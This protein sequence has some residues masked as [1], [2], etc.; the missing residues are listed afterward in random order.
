MPAQAGIHD[1]LANTQKLTKT[2]LIPPQ[3]PRHAGA[4]GHLCE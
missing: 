3:T 4:S 2:W 1:F